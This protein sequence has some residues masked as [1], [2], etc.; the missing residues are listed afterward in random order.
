[1]RT[2]KKTAILIL[3]ALLVLTII[4]IAACGSG[5]TGSPETDPATTTVTTT[6]A[7]EGP[8]DA[9]DDKSVTAGSMAEESSAESTEAETSAGTSAMTVASSTAAQRS[10]ATAVPTTS[11]TTTPT[12]K[13]AVQ[14]VPPPATAAQ[15]TITTRSAMPTTTVTPKTNPLQPTYTQAD[16]DEIVAA[17]RAYAESKTLVRFTW[18]PALTYEYARSGRAGYHDLVDLSPTNGKEYVIN[19]L[20]YHVDLTE[21]RGI[22]GSGGIPSYTVDYNIVYFEYQNELLFCLIYG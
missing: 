21:T 8:T 18:N 9:A 13:P 10:T 22:T 12:A 20:K 14:A 19:R 7:T 15:T 16:Y 1:M 6:M 3:L 11:P 5:P 4:V 17:V 2:M